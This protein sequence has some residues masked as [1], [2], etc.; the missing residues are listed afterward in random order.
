M[1][2]D[3]LV[4]VKNISLTFFDCD[5]GVKLGPISHILS[6]SDL[7]TIR[8][9]RYKNT[10]L[11]GGY[12]KRETGSPMMEMKVI[13]DVRVPMAYYQGCVSVSAQVEYENGLLYTGLDGNTTDD[14]SSDTHE[15]TLKLNFLE[16]DEVLPT[17][18]L[19]NG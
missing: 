2:C 13:R 8:T 16:I 12:V 3:L 1:A 5:T 14:S 7:P 9:C 18:S 10:D 4:G 19:A 6:S 15:V 11:P 17:G